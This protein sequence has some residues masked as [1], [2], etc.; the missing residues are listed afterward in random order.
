MWAGFF[1]KEG[2]VKTNFPSACTGV[3]A[4]L[5]SLLAVLFPGGLLSGR[6]QGKNGAVRKLDGPL[7]RLFGITIIAILRP[8][9]IPRYLGTYMHVPK[10]L[11]ISM[12][13]P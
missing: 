5:A 2:G 8:I 7:L 4:R 12:Y 1:E 10:Y 11:E 3:L 9:R 13:L 6:R